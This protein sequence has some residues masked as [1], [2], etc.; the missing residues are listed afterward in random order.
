MTLIATSTFNSSTRF[1][2][3]VGSQLDAIS[4]VG[5]DE[6]NTAAGLQTR[7]DRKYLV[8]I[9]DSRELIEQLADQAQ[10]LEIAGQRQFRYESV[11]FDTADRDSFAAAAHGRRR[12]FKVRLRRYL[13]SGE[14]WLEVKARGSRGITMKERLPYLDESANQLTVAGAE[15]VTN[16]L[17][18]VQIR[19]C[20]PSQ[21]RPVLTTRYARSTLLLAAENS[22]LTL[23]TGLQVAAPDGRAIGLP[24]LVVIETKSARATSAADKQLWRSGHRPTRI[25]KF[26][27]GLA[28][29]YPQLPSNKWHRVIS[30]HFSEQKNN[31]KDIA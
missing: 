21:L 15:F 8:P 27:T 28:A 16:C 17:Q 14:C 26:A 7:I 30:R 25:S 9:M 1:A 13:D 24:G 5:L 31:F 29:L 4:P 19:D 12:R 20:D 10:V 18:A 11:Y 22:R 3:P 6:L 2:N 23:D